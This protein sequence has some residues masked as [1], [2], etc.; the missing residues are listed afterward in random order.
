[1]N[2]LGRRELM[3][4]GA[5]LLL[6]QA[7]GLTVASAQESGSPAKLIPPPMPKQLPDDWTK[8]PT[9]DIWPSEPP[10]ASG[11]MPQKLPD[12]WPAIF[13][14]NIARPQLHVFRAARPNGQGLLAIPGGAYWFVSVA[15]EGVDLAKR[16]NALGITVFVLTYRLPGEGWAHR[17]D[18]PLQD[19]QRS[20]RVIRSQAAKFGINADTLGVLGFSAGGNLTATL[21]TD[22]GQRV[23]E[24]VDA[25]DRLSARPFSAGLIYPVITMKKE[26]THPKSRDL[27]LGE[28]PT[29]AE[30][31]RRC[32]ELHVAADTPPTFIAHAMDDTDVPVENSLRMM[33]ALRAANRPVETHL[34]QEGHHAFGVGYPKT[35]SGYWID[36][37]GAWR[38][39]LPS[40]S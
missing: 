32:P 39:R 4:A 38:A 9:I 25:T 19:A 26:W 37:Y 31:D 40:P 36:L 18:V 28:N 30:V 11:Y 7:S 8:A 1:M 22:H 20:M 27:L 10:G 29:E 21:A 6:A 13:V 33:S 35:P 34:F 23:Y 12:D 15:N 24:N 16:L 2:D 3:T 5:A 17:S 14:R